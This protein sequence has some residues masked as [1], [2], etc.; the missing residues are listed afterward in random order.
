M[1]L[2][3]DRE[4]SS[5]EVPDNGLR[6]V[7]SNR[8]WPKVSKNDSPTGP[9]VIV[10]R[11]VLDRECLGR[12]FQDHNPDLAIVVVGSL[13]ELRALPVQ[14]EPSVILLVLGERKATDPATREELHEF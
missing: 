9:V 10:H 8:A 12:S 3:L 7:T 1:V 13:D 4:F 11:R 6:S 5:E 2:A 14:A